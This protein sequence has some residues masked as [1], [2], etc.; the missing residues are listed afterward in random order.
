VSTK[1]ALCGDISALPLARKS[2]SCGWQQH[3]LP[4]FLL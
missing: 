1:A 4:R 3:A 2:I